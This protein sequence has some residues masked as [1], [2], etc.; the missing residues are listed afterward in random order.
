[1]CVRARVRSRRA[2]LDLRTIPPL[3]TRT[4]TPARVM[5]PLPSEAPSWRSVRGAQPNSQHTH[6][7]THTH[8]CLH[9]CM[10]D[11][12]SAF[13]VAICRS[14]RGA[15]RASSASSAFL[16]SSSFLRNCV[17]VEQACTCT[18]SQLAM[19]SIRVYV[20]VCV[21]V[22]ARA[23]VCVCVAQPLPQLPSTFHRAPCEIVWRQ[24]GVT[25]PHTKTPSSPP[26]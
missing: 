1:M 17:H 25:Q 21:Y 26:R 3:S 15:R 24:C 14:V 7:C 18:L 19:P 2:G 9:T 23:R 22:R 13:S 4:I 5:P 10:C 12:T 11:A 6:A 16:F 20:C 8:F